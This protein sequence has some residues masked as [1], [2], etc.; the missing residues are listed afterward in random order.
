MKK[1]KQP[2]L[3]GYGFGIKNITEGIKETVIATAKRNIVVI[4]FFH[5]YSIPLCVMKT[6][7]CYETCITIQK[8]G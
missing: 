7:T 8:C 5:C 1:I 4:F 3:T 6:Q 2:E